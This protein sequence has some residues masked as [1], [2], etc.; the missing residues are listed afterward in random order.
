MASGA[1][2]RHTGAAGPLLSRHPSTFEGYAQS[3]SALRHL[4]RCVAFALTALC[5]LLAASRRRF[6]GPADRPQRDRREDRGQREG[7]GAL[8]VSQ[9]RRR[10]SRARVG[11]DQR[12]RSAGGR[13]PGEVQARLLRRLGHRATRCYWKHFGSTCGR[14]DGPALPNVVAACKAP[15]GSYWA[16][17]SWPQP[18]PDLGFTPWTPKFS[19]QWLEV[20]HWTG[21]A[22]AARDRL[23][24]GLQRPL[25]GALRP[26][27]PTTASRSTVSA[28]RASAPR[29]TASA[30][31]IYLDTYNSVYGP[32]WRR[33]NSFVSHNPTGVFCYGFYPFDPTK[34]GYQHPPGW[35]A[36]R[37][38]GHG[39][40]VPAHR[41][42]PRR[43]AE[44]RGVSS[45]APSVRPGERRGHRLAAA[46]DQMCCSR[47]TTGSVAPACPSRVRRARPRRLGRRGAAAPS[48]PPRKR[49][50]GSTTSP[51]AAS[52]RPTCRSP[53]ALA[54]SS[55]W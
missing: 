20:S 30:A 42:R 35:T 15:D 23:Q 4:P 45:R 51:P 48:R 34:G 36:K 31:S 19:A 7:R 52:S 5:L 37:G 39:R 41:E 21:D 8:H 33:E 29:P 44:R 50:R 32:G 25:P 13:P 17:Q 9:G 14:Y 27:S 38:P 12:D 40:E 43:D 55:R 54:S 10:P 16:A 47:G 18:L 6:G 3:R 24:L 28:R 26:A 22:R 1:Y 11:R 2:E 49:W 53:Q 46:A